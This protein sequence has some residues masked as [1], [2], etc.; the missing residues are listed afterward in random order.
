MAIDQAYFVS[1]LF[2]AFT[3]HF[4]L[5]HDLFMHLQACALGSRLALD[6]KER[7]EREQASNRQQASKG[8]LT[9]DAA[10]RRIQKAFRK[11][12]SQVLIDNSSN[13]VPSH[14]SPGLPPEE[15]VLNDDNGATKHRDNSANLVVLVATGDDEASRDAATMKRQPDAHEAA[16]MI[17]RN[18]LG[19]MGRRC[20]AATRR[21]TIATSGLNEGNSTIEGSVQANV[22][23]VGMESSC[24]L[25]FQRVVKTRLLRAI[26]ARRIA[27]KFANVVE[28]ASKELP[29][30]RSSLKKR[31]RTSQ[32]S[33][34]ITIQ[35]ALRRRLARR[36]A[37]DKR[38]AKWLSQASDD[39]ARS[40]A[41]D[42]EEVQPSKEP[43]RRK[44]LKATSNA[45]GADQASRSLKRPH[46]RR[47]GVQIEGGQTGDEKVADNAI[48]ATGQ[49]DVSMPD[50]GS[51][52]GHEDS[53]RKRVV[54]VPLKGTDIIRLVQKGH[55]FEAVGLRISKVS[56]IFMSTARRMQALCEAR[57]TRRVNLQKL[58]GDRLA[59][60]RSPIEDDEAREILGRT[61]LAIL[62]QALYEA[63]SRPCPFKSPLEMCLSMLR[64]AAMSQAIC[65]CG[66][67]FGDGDKYCKKCDMS[68]L[69]AAYNA[70]R[71]VIFDE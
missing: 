56:L 40:E 61:E 30:P 15:G 14:P 13:D 12:V 68:R 62:V 38:I 26:R 5:T 2:W 54:N 20:T 19:W 9:K 29:A 50:E 18:L 4:E 63:L 67:T 49:A 27:G 58:G 70:N 1:H 11:M 3:G 60:A 64:V 55:L 48:E 25:R 31:P 10:A 69:K 7:T 16:L 53:R 24:A 46:R 47:M 52:V 44:N 34:A 42:G 21:S 28:A 43:T 71:V 59:G 39:D 45:S 23:V 8:T 6:E 32:T 35:C 66:N 37:Q 36:R 65:H 33:A 17:Q 57:A 41:K 51:A 22:G